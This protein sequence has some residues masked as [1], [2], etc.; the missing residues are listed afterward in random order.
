MNNFLVVHGNLID[1][2]I[3]FLTHIRFERLPIFFD[4]LGFWENFL[5]IG[6]IQQHTIRKLLLK[7]AQPCPLTEKPMLFYIGKA[8]NLHHTYCTSLSNNH[9]NNQKLLK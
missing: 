9:S 6:E 7:T 2:K 4:V 5:F 3:H 1:K 8:K